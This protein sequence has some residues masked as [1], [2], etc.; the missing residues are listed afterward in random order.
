MLGGALDRGRPA[1]LALAELGRGASSSLSARMPVS[2][3]RISC[4]SSA[5][6]ASIRRV[7]G[8]DFARRAAARRFF[9]LSAFVPTPA[10]TAMPGTAGHTPALGNR[11]AGFASA[12]SA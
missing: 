3:V 12:L 10:E 6:V 11:I 1:A 7:R 5:S 2:G 4:A 8:S 9:G